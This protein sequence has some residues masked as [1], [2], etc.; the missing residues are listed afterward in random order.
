MLQVDVAGDHADLYRQPPADLGGPGEA[1]GRQGAPGHHHH[2][3]GPGVR[4]G[5]LKA[6]SG[7]QRVRTAQ[8]HRPFWS[9]Y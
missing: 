2:L 7:S 3:Q 8:S 4:Q 6:P 5:T 9:R 1:L